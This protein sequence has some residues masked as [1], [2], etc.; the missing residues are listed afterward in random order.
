MIENRMKQLLLILWLRSVKQESS[1]SQFS[2]GCC[3]VFSCP[4][5]FVPPRKPCKTV[6]HENT[7]PFS[8][9][10]ELRNSVQPPTD[11][12]FD[13]SRYIKLVPPFRE[14]EVDAYFVTFEC[15]AGRAGPE[16][17]I[18]RIFVRWVGIRFSILRFEYPFFFRFSTCPFGWTSATD[19][20]P[21]KDVRAGLCIYFMKN[22]LLWARL[23]HIYIWNNE[24]KRAKDATCEPTL[25]YHKT[26]CDACFFFLSTVPR[27]ERKS[28]ISVQT[29]CAD[30][31]PLWESEREKTWY[32]WI[33]HSVLIC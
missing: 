30:V 3:S 13:V 21:M 20:S 9:F 17:L 28:W 10:L 33:T 14:A 18:I 12:P 5:E 6:L 32:S 24:L 23:P 22:L 19:R 29:R 2:Q 16:Y 31:K 1:T 15:I 4:S 7:S 25:C 11:A 26:E 27:C 8:A